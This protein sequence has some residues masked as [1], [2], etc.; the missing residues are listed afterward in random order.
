[1]IQ[2]PELR[3]RIVEL[4]R[5]LGYQ[6]VSVDLEGYRTG[7]MNRMLEGNLLPRGEAGNSS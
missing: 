7:S 6:Y 2:D 1:M 5:S 3:D 4:F